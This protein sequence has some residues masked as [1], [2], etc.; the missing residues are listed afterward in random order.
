MV[1]CTPFCQIIHCN[2]SNMLSVWVKK[3]ANADILQFRFNVYFLDRK[4]SLLGM[5]TLYV[6]SDVQ[7]NSL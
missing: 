3:L 4:H 7:H 5:K 6:P 1:H 2:L